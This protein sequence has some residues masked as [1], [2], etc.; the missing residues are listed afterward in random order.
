MNLENIVSLVAALGLGGILT[1]AWDY[2]AKRRQ[3]K[4]DGEASL[5][6]SD[7]Q[8]LREVRQSLNQELAELRRSY[9]DV[10]NQVYSLKAELIAEKR[11]SEEL[12]EELARKPA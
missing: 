3:S 2:W 7:R 10:M 4:E 12:R 8:E 5:Q 9:F 11:I 1:K 6:L